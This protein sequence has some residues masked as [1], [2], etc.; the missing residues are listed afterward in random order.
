MKAFTYNSD[1]KHVAT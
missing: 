1:H